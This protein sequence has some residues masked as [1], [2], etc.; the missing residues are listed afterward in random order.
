[1]TP[2]EIA[3]AVPPT[4]A[5]WAAIADDHLRSL[6]MAY[7]IAN[8]SPSALPGGLGKHLANLATILGQAAHFHRTFAELCETAEKRLIDA[9]LS[10]R[11]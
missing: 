2:T 8:G 6:R 1:M 11:G 4:P 5:E 10:R 3:A 9:S 7:V